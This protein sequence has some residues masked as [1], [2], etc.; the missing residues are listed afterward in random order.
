MLAPRELPA[1]PAIGLPESHYAKLIHRADKH[2][3]THLREALKVA[4]YVTLGVDP[5][6][7][8]EKKQR[9]FEHAIRRHCEP[10]PLASEET[11][12]F[13]MQL[14]DLVKQHAGQEA[15]KIA[16]HADDAYAHR[17]RLGQ[18]ADDLRGEARMFFRRIMGDGEV[19]PVTFS[20]DDWH[21]L[22]L[23]RNQWV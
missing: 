20:E 10:P 13:Y 7:P 6:L 11:W 19:K 4:Q 1:L 21:Q 22:K 2:G 15:L 14:K 3:D 16:S 9:Y 23:M 17:M 5:H 12:L 18:S 8:W